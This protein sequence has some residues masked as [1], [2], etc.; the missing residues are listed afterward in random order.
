MFLDL[1]FL[2]WFQWRFNVVN[3]LPYK[4][5]QN[6]RRKSFNCSHKKWFDA[7]FNF[8]HQQER[9]FHSVPKAFYISW[10]SLWYFVNS[11]VCFLLQ[12]H[13]VRRMNVTKK[14]QSKKKTWNS[15]FF[16]SFNTG[17]LSWSAIKSW[18]EKY[19][20]S[21][22]PLHIL[23][24]SKRLAASIECDKIICGIHFNCTNDCYNGGI[25][26]KPNHSHGSNNVFNVVL[27]LKASFQFN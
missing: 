24:C 18:W 11:S 14:K 6:N 2:L 8:C 17:V 20:G 9:R 15:D 22:W 27:N 13:H 16:R 12:R 5:Q 25:T 3:V 26:K 4:Q 7:A 23:S 10:F 21:R 1:L 19:I